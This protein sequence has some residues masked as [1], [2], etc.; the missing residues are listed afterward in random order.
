MNKRMKLVVDAS[1]IGAGAMLSQY[2]RNTPKEEELNAAASRKFS[3]IEQR[4]SQ[5]ESESQA[6]VWA[7]EKFR[8]YLTG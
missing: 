5:V 4:Y 3:E 1:P 8:I 2:D 7:C 6:I